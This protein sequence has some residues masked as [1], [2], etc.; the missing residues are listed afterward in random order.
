MIVKEFLKYKIIIIE[1]ENNVKNNIWYT[2]G[3]FILM[4]GKSHNNI[5]K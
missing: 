4:Y 5:V 2:C 1:Q 3:W